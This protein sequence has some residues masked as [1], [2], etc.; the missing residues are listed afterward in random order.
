MNNLRVNARVLDV[1]DLTDQIYRMR[2]TCDAFGPSHPGQ[3]VN[4]TVPEFF[5]RRPLAIADIETG[6]DRSTILTMIVAKVG[7]GTRALAQVV[8]GTQVDVLGP[9]GNGFD[10]DTVGPNPVLV[11]GGSGIP[12]LYYAA[13]ELTARGARPHVLLGFRSARDTYSIDEFEKL[14]CDVSV[15]TEDGSLGTAGYVT[16]VLP[17]DAE[18][19]L[20]CGP[21]G[22]LTSVV[23]LATGRVQVSLEAHMGCG[24][25][26]CLGCTVHTVRGLERVCLEGPVFESTDV[27]FDKEEA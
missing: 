12:P 6:E 24:F 20:A 7:A 23:A 18:Q 14:G 5:L 27:L 26:A 25:G 13:K 1:T 3:F 19:V 4:L 16:A 10:L 8:P 15:A 9:L 22:M 11:G 2:L 21:H 17:T